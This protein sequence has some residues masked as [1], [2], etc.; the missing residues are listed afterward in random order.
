MRSLIKGASIGKA[1][2]AATFVIVLAFSMLTFNYAW[3]DSDVEGDSS[4]AATEEAQ[5]TVQE[6]SDKPV[7]RGEIDPLI[8]PSTLVVG[9]EYEWNVT[10]GPD[11]WIDENGVWWEP[12]SNAP[13]TP[14]D[15]NRAW[16]LENL[17]FSSSDTSVI[18]ASLR[19]DEEGEYIYAQMEAVGA[20]TATLT[21]SCRYEGSSEIYCAETSVEVTVAAESSKVQTVTLSEDALSIGFISECAICGESHGDNEENEIII[22]MADAAGNT[23]LTSDISVRS[24]SR[25]PDIADL[26]YFYRLEDGRYSAVISAHALGDT[27]IDIYN[28]TTGEKAASISVSVHEAEKPTFIG[29]KTATLDSSYI[30]NEEISGSQIA[31]RPDSDC[32]GSYEYGEYLQ[33]LGWQNCEDTSSCTDHSRFVFGQS[34]VTDDNGTKEV[35]S[36]TINDQSIATVVTNESDELEIK[37]L[38]EGTTTVYFKDIWGNENS[39]ELTVLDYN[40]EA[41]ENYKVSESAKELTIAVGD[42]IDLTQYIEG[43]AHRDEF[44]CRSEDRNIAITIHDDYNEEAGV[45]TLVGCLPGDTT[46]SLGVLF[47]DDCGGNDRYLD[48]MNTVDFGEIKLH[49]VDA[50]QSTMESIAA[51]EASEYKASIVGL[52]KEIKNRLTSNL[53][54]RL[55]AQHKEPSADLET[56]ITEFL[57]RWYGEAQ[58]SYELVDFYCVDKSDNKVV[59]DEDG[60]TRA[61]ICLPFTDTMKQLNPDTIQIRSTDDGW[62]SPWNEYSWVYNGSLYFVA[63]VEDSLGEYLVMGETKDPDPVELTSDSVAAINDA[64][65]S[66]SAIEPDVTVVV[67]GQTLVRDTDYTVAYSDNTNAGTATVTITGIGD[68]TGELTKTFKINPAGIAKAE[69]TTKDQTYTGAALKPEVTVKIGDVSLKSGTDYSVAYSS[70]IN[71][72]TATVTITG[73]GNYTGTATTTFTIARKSLAASMVGSLASQ[74]YTGSALKPAPSV[75]DGATTLKNGT[76]YTLSYSSNTKVGTAKVTITGKGNYTGTV[77]KTFKIN[78]ASVA[79]AKVTT[80]TQTYTGKSLTPNPTVKVGNKTLKKNTDYTLTYKNNKK[81]GKATVT[82]KGKGNYTGSISKT[83][84]IKPAKVTGVKATSSNKGKVTVKWSN[85]K[86][87]AANVTGYK[88]VVKSGSKTIKTQYVSGK[89]SKSKTITLANKYKGKKVKVYVYAYKTIDKTKVC[90]AASSASTVKVK[91]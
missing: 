19:E 81:T 13:L 73:K 5:S 47:G 11:E 90:S 9:Q 15:A 79:K 28:P 8:L 52:P 27:V 38:K 6:T 39:T 64:V 46:V 83:F 3:A 26:A 4:S 24:E 80:K 23:N 54:N 82:I 40:K 7:F 37:P 36:V 22:S 2:S 91:K 84:N 16:S 18:K 12:S 86:G 60:S 69:V 61:V 45:C 87:K 14:E 29:N 57:S 78:P 1:I 89:S 44:V 63:D 53:V 75:K 68:Y 58:T 48:D 30:G 55:V 43:T 71:A 10:W 65:Y 21:L 74:T 70:N 20:G 66:G 17:A 31:I 50:Q 88:V 85:S 77:T 56:T 42:R 25:N 34:F 35:Y 62:A 76:D 51:S 49:V 41:Q 59:L 32:L 72:G 33:L 67:D